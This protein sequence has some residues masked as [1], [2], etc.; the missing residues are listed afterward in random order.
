MCYNENN[1]QI[2]KFYFVGSRLS[3]HDNQNST[4]IT[5]EPG[6]GTVH[7]MMCANI[8]KWKNKKRKQ[9]TERIF[10]NL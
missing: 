1:V 9:R 3:C 4:N 2:D 10:I 7:A 8:G 6:T 5:E